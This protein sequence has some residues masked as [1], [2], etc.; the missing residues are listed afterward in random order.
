MTKAELEALIDGGDLEAC[1]AA[2]D[3]MPEAERNK[4]GAAA[5]ARLRELTKGIHPRLAP[6]LDGEVAHFAIRQIVMDHSRSARFRAARAAVL[7]TASFSQWQSVKSRGLP[8]NEQ[9]FRILSN[10]RPPWLGE[11]VEQICDAEEHHL[12]S[13]W[14][15]IRQLVREGYCEQPR[16]GRYI[17]RMLQAL[18]HRRGHSPAR[19]KDVLLDD[20]GLLEHEIWRIFETEPGPGAI[21]L[22][23]AKTQGVHPETTWDGALADLAREGRISRERLLDATLDGLSRDFHETRAK[24]FAYLHDQLEPTPA[25][26]AARVARY[27]DLL[28]SRNASTVGFA[29]AEI[30]NLVKKGMLEPSAIVDPMARAMHCR[31]KGTVKQALSLLELVV[32]RSGDAGLKARA[33]MIATEGLVHDS[34][35]IQSAVL[36][37]LERHGDRHNRSLR[38]LLAARRDAIAVS[39]RGRLESW[40]E[41]AAEPE[42]EVAADEDELADLVSRAAGLSRRFAALAGVHDALAVV[43]GER[44][45]LSALKFDGTKIPRLDPSRR[46]EPIDD[47]DTL[48]ELCSRLVETVKPLED[49]DR[50]VD[51]ISRL[52]DLRP[53]DFQK[54][55]APL[56]ARV[57]QRLDASADMSQYLMHH[58]G[59]IVRSWV[60]GEVPDPQPYDGYRPLE[61]FLTSWAGAL[62]RRVAK[63]RAAPLLAAPTHAGGWIDPRVLVTRFHQR[64]SMPLADE[65]EDLILAILRLAPDYRSTA[66]AEA[67]DLPG[68]QGAA[69]RYALGSDG[70][71]I[72]P[73]A[74]LWVTAARSRSPF[75]DD[76]HVEARHP[77]LGPDAGRAALYRIIGKELIASRG[78]EANLHVHLEPAVPEGKPALAATP[79]VA[80]HAVL[81]LTSDQWPSPVSLW[82]SGPECFCACGAQQLLQAIESSSDWQGCRGYLQP[83]FD[84]DFPLGPMARL[85]LCLSL[86]AKLPEV[87][88]LATDAIVAAIDDGRLDADTL[89]ES[90][91]N[92]WQ[93]T[94]ETYLYGPKVDPY[95]NLKHLVPF[96]KPS[97]WVKGLGDVARISP[98]HARIIARAIEIF[99]AAETSP[100]R[101]PASLLP[102]LELLRET[103][104]ESGRAISADAHKYLSGLGT[105]GKTGRV[106]KELLALRDLPES[107][108]MRN[109]RILAL[110]R[111][112][113]RAERWATCERS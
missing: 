81:W 40:L 69:I 7:A 75:S 25:E 108:G 11:L 57:R 88:G 8:S 77:G 43:R 18:L 6:L 52:C 24:W 31:T 111:R 107:P 112:I 28:G 79:T 73:T 109:A 103:S 95:K 82:P 44:S 110:A 89:G 63:A 37:F 58:F 65:P 12:T 99:L 56:S 66:L 96:V 4:L 92:V 106:V 101:A 67:R 17:D 68:E 36:D 48:I 53:A 64:L 83:L 20:P 13:R 21:Q 85:S 27:G 87:A 39:L 22:F 38:D 10:R 91:G 61:H 98:M 104:V 76:Q 72:G 84:P 2:F 16:S 74:A 90:L 1:I 3:G 60:T 113:E 23:T 5:V 62:A 51:A 49:V 33:V 100:D 46:L 42:H 50:C 26:R 86:N 41:L 55:T 19:L 14:P 94:V 47:L 78:T 93:A 45:D 80:F 15:L 9:V 105:G 32:R 97:R 29:L 35:D 30:V 71:T 102:F 59:V 54:R 70:E 34:A